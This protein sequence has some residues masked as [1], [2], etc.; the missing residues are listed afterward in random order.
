MPG[1]R[2][3]L[4]RGANH[5][6]YD[7]NFCQY[8]GNTNQYDKVAASTYGN[9]PVAPYT[10]RPDIPLGTDTVSIIDYGPDSSAWAQT[11]STLDSLTVA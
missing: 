1:A 9:D 7:L 10:S 6:I 4:R 2:R 3:L 8:N 5:F 11:N